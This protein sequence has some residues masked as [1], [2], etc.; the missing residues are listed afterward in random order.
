[1]MSQPTNPLVKRAHVVDAYVPAAGAFLRLSRWMNQMPTN[2]LT[3]QKIADKK[4]NASDALQRPQVP[5]REIWDHAKVSP[6][7]DPELLRH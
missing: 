2:A 1:M 3:I 6:A 7:Q 4:E 5:R